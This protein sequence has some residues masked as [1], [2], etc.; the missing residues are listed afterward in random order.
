MQDLHSHPL[1]GCAGLPPYSGDRIKPQN[2]NDLIS[3]T[4]HSAAKTS[5]SGGSGAAGTKRGAFPRA[6][7]GC[8]VF[9]P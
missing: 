4:R 3:I 5:P 2:S 8:M 7:P 6:K 9:P 1:S